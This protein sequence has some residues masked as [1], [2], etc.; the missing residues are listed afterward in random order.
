MPLRKI[1][2]EFD[3]VE[4]A[5]GLLAAMRVVWGR[6]TGTIIMNPKR[7]SWRWWK[8]RCIESTHYPGGRTP[9]GAPLRM[10]KEKAL[11]EGKNVWCGGEGGI[12]THVG[13]QTQLVFETS[14]FNR[15]VTSPYS[16]L[17]LGVWRNARTS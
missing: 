7:G 14:T 2:L 16:L 12:R 6:V 9:A 10:T 13:F 17:M 4:Q 15:S 5:K 11:P 8:P 3:T 1:D